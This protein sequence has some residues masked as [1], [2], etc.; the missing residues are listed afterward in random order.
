MDIDELIEQETKSLDRVELAAKI[1]DHALAG[2][3]LGQTEAR[4]WFGDEKTPGIV[5]TKPDEDVYQAW[6]ERHEEVCEMLELEP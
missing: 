5:T 3:I 4:V 1:G 6:K 2:R